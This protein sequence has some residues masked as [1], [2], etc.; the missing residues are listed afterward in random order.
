ME[1]S[2]IYEVQVGLENVLGFHFDT[3]GDAIDFAAIC[4]DNGYRTLIIPL[5][6]ENE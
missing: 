4:L 6:A 5:E 3:A 1:N 2:I